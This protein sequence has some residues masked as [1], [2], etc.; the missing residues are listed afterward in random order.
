MDITQKYKEILQEHFLVKSILKFP[1]KLHTLVMLLIQVELSQF[2]VNL[3]KSRQQIL[4]VIGILATLAHTAQA[5]LASFQVA[6]HSPHSQ[7]MQM[8]L[9]FWIHAVSQLKKLP[10]FSA[11]HS[12]C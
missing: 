11:F 6:L 2:Q 5:K 12:H 10:V 8:M 4:A 7:L 3:L 9:N 1:P